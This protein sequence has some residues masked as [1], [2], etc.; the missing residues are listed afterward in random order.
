MD[1]AVSA[2]YRGSR[3]RNLRRRVFRCVL[4]AAEM[5]GVMGLEGRGEFE[6][7]KTRARVGSSCRTEGGIRSK[8]DA[9]WKF[10]A[11]LLRSGPRPLH[12]PPLQSMR[13]NR[14]T[15]TPV[16]PIPT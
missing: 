5:G 12:L 16:P 6:E 14:P 8:A 1:F 10:A 7:V 15:I 4:T 2:I 9:P 13:A 11:P 3:S